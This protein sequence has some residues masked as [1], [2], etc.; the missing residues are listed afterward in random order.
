[1]VTAFQVIL[2]IVI[3]L[4]FMAM[5]GEKDNENLVLSTAGLCI[6]AIG[7]FLVSAMWL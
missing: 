4:G 7:A 5:I 6:A 1:M 3:V 2:L